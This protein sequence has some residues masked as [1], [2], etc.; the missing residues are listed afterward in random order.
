M[1]KFLGTDNIIG[2]RT[3]GID[4]RLS[5]LTDKREVLTRKMEA[6]EIRYLRQFNALD[7]MMAQMR[8][9]SDYLTQQLDALP[10][11]YVKK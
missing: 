5:D 2:T 4:S 7:T 9:T 11:A 1:A 8:S 6:L 3:D 10:G